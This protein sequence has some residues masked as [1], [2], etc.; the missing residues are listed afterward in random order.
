MRWRLSF[1]YNLYNFVRVVKHG[2]VDLV[3]CQSTTVSAGSERHMNRLYCLA[4]PAHS[5]YYQ[6]NR[7]VFRLDG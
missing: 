2:S 5:A 1:N 4:F 6:S 3:S 7:T